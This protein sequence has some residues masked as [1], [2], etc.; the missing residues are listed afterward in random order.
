MYVASKESKSKEK[1]VTEFIHY[2]DG[3]IIETKLLRKLIKVRTI[4]KHAN[5]P[6]RKLIHT[7]SIIRNTVARLLLDRYQTIFFSSQ[8]VKIGEREY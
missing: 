7:V 3:C 1:E 2:N 8:E 4:F 6:N 5:N